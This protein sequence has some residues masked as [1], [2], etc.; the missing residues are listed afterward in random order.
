MRPLERIHSLF[1]LFHS[2][3]KTVFMIKNLT[4]SV[5]SL[6]KV[7]LKVTKIYGLSNQVKFQIEAKESPSVEIYHQ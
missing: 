4:D 3:S 5:K 2:M 7:D 6:I 1:C